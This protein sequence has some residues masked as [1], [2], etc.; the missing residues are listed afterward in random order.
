MAVTYELVKQ[1]TA[2]LYEWS[3][4]GIP[5]NSRQALRE[6]QQN[7]ENANARRTLTFMLRS[8][9]AAETSGRFVCSDAGVPTYSVKIGCGARLEG[10]IRQAI[11]DG[12]DHLVK[13]IEPP[14]LQFVTNPLTNE[15]SYRGKDM[16]LVSYDLLGDVD[17]V[18][19]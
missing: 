11:V 13:T 7:E 9:E 2:E 14:L 1:V 18:D 3:L 12:F 17:Y 19:I 10:D 16:P 6:A 4:K 8:A 5:A 15:R